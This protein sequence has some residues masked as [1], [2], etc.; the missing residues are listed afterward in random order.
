MGQGQPSPTHG[1]SKVTSSA[2]EVFIAR[3]ISAAPVIDE[4]GH[5][6]GVLSRSDVMIHQAEPCL[7]D[8]TTV[9]ELMTPAVFAVSP[10]TAAAEVIESLLTLQVHRL[11]VL[12]AEGA[13]VGVIT[14]LDVLRHLHA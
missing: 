12:D 8:P 5:P 7:A 3:A 4:A 1:A 14:P 13:L 9:E 2:R 10:E 11:F 6:I